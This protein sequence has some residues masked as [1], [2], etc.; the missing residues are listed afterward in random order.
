MPYGTTLHFFKK[1]IK[2]QWEDPS[3]SKGCR[4][5]FKSEKS[6]TSKLWEDMLLA[7]VGEQI[8]NKAETFVG[9]ILNLKP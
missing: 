6:H 5:S 9:L 3:L 2:P 1:G 7:M 8:G 4:L